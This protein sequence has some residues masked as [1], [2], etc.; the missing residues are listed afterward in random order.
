[1][2]RKFIQICLV[3]AWS[4]TLLG[5]QRSSP[6]GSPSAHSEMPLPGESIYNL[7]SRW[8]DQSGREFQLRSLRGKA[9]VVAMIY[10]GCQGACPRI[11]EELRQV[12]KLIS[13]KSSEEAGFVLVTMDPE[14]DSSERLSALARQ[15]ELGPRWRLLRGSQEETRELAAALGVKYKKISDTDFAHSNTI[16][17][18]SSSGTVAHQKQDLGGVEKSVRALE[19]AVATKDLCCP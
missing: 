7:E 19:E 17:V 12:E 4:I 14:V 5:C 18:L 15:Y 8:L 3:L 9:Q 13:E 2:M 6:T 11:I 10:G 16:T 1:M